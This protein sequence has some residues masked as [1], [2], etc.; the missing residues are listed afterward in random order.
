MD[1]PGTKI[2]LEVKICARDRGNEPVPHK[3]LHSNEEF[4]K[5]FY[6]YY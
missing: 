6:A 4:V 1:R 2:Q 5:P 3:P